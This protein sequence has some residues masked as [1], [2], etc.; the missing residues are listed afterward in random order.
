VKAI[1]LIDHGSRRTEANEMLGCMAALV[2]RLAGSEVIVRFAHMELAEP[3]IPRGVQACIEAGATE[4]IAFPYMLSPGRHSTADIP[5]LVGEAARQYSGV[6]VRVTP[7]FGVDAL[8]GEVI[9]RRAGIEAAESLGNDAA[10]ECW[11]AEGRIGACGDGC[12]ALAANRVA[13][14]L[15]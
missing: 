10:C 13:H 7:A 12:P 6:T 1:L 14:A 11:H 15:P 3:S 4:L 2:Q 8:L 9:L 5:R